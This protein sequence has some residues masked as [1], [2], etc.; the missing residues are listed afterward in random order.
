MWMSALNPMDFTLMQY[1]VTDI[2]NAKEGRFVWI[3]YHLFICYVEKT[4]DFII[5]VLNE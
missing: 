5:N 1:N 2:T 4:S 3:F